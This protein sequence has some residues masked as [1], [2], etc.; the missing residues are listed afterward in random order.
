ML[1]WTVAHA[2]G[3]PPHVGLHGGETVPRAAGEVLYIIS[4]CQGG[5]IRLKQVS[6]TALG[7]EAAEPPMGSGENELNKYMEWK[8]RAVKSVEEK[9]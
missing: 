4:M 8:S 1:S 3:L 5:A 2:P 9:L 7:S 6:A